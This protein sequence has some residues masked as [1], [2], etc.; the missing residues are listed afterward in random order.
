MPDESATTTEQEQDERNA[1]ATLVLF[2]LDPSN[3]RTECER[4]SALLAV[5]WLKR[6][7]F[8]PAAAQ[9]ALELHT[10]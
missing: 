4:N 5:Q 3:K 9:L 2:A 6:T 7:G 8:L 1:V 10:S